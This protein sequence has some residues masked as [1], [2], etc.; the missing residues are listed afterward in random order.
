MALKALLESLDG[1]DTTLVEHYKEQTGPGGKKEFVLD[2]EGPTDALPAVKTVK[3]EAA[4]NRTKMKEFE[5]KYGALKAFEGMN[6]EEVRQKLDRIEELEAAAGGK[7]DQVAIDKIVETRIKT[8]LAPLERE[9][10]GLKQEKI[11][12]TQQIEGFQTANKQRTIA[13][14]IR[15]AATKDK[16]LP[17]AVED[18]IMLGERQLELTDDGKAAVKDSG[19]DVVN[20]LNDVK[21]KR[22]H[23]WPATVGGGARGGSGN[24]SGEINPWGADTWNVTAQGTMVRTDKL[25]AEA[26]AKRAG[27]TIGGKR[28]VAKK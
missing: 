13:D 1:L 15:A 16:M 19:L 12:L 7:L 5:T 17:E 4:T 24:G 20:W 22:P 3:A 10:D 23:W 9:R 28:P 8:R 21:A 11:T 6:A 18:A 26:M 2:L 14:Q 25:K 27:T